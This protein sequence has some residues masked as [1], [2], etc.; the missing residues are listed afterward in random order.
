MRGAGDRAGSGI[1]QC[2][3]LAVR[4]MVNPPVAAADRAGVGERGDV[5]VILNRIAALN[6]AGVGDGR[7]GFGR[8]AQIQSAC[9]PLN[10]A[11]SLIVDRADVGHRVYGISARDGT[12]VLNRCG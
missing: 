5:S 8:I 2:A 7:D 4:A 10:D 1:R 9:C 11:A 6:R 3:Q 12:G